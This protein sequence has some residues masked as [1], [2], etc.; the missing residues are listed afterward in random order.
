[1]SETDGLAAAR[2]IRDDKESLSADARIW[3]TASTA[4]ATEEDR[5]DGV[6]AEMDDYLS[7]PVAARALISAL[8]LAASRAPA[9]ASV[10]SAGSKG[11]VASDERYGREAQRA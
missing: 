3:I 10:A 1:M 11:E 7:K 2:A 5:R 9:R 4:N 8:E 6:D